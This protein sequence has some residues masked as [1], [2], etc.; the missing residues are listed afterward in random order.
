MYVNM[1]RYYFPGWLSNAYEDCNNARNLVSS[2]VCKSEYFNRTSRS[3]PFDRDEVCLGVKHAF[4][5]KSLLH[6][7]FSTAT[8][9]KFLPRR[10]KKWKYRNICK[11]KK[12]SLYVKIY[13]LRTLSGT[14]PYQLKRFACRIQANMR[15]GSNG[16]C[17]RSRGF[18]ETAQ[19][20]LPLRIYTH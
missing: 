7:Q 10:K 1:V 2:E 13:G 12:R 14:R 15:V 9:R 17:N 6:G 20:A 4:A 16:P 11:N 18:T 8:Q 3:K 5:T 19:G